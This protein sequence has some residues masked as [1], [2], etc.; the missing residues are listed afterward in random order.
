MDFAT[1]AEFEFTNTKVKEFIPFYGPIAI[2][3][4][5]LSVA[6]TKATTLN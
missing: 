1:Y 6:A 5:P 4:R 3:L 2:G